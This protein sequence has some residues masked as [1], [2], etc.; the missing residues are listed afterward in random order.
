LFDPKANPEKKT[1]KNYK[2][3]HVRTSN[4]GPIER[5]VR[6]GTK[7]AKREN[8][9]IVPGGEKKKDWAGISFKKKKNKLGKANAFDYGWTKRLR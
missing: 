2:K 7:R 8:P 5:T 4:S 6:N 1:L 9:T 3:T